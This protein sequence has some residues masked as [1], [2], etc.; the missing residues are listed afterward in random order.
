MTGPVP[1]LTAT[2]PIDRRFVALRRRRN[3]AWGA[4]LAVAALVL[5]TGG[6]ARFGPVPLAVGGLALAAA[7][8][9][10]LV[11]DFR[12]GTN[13][14]RPG[15][16]TPSFVLGT[17]GSAGFAFAQS[18][19][20]DLRWVG[21]LVH[22]E[23][24]TVTGAAADDGF[25]V[26]PPLDGVLGA[27]SGDLGRVPS[28]M[29]A[30]AVDGPALWLCFPDRDWLVC[31]PRAAE[32]AH[33][34]DTLGPVP[35]PSTGSRAPVA[36]ST[37]LRQGRWSAGTS[38]AAPDPAAPSAGAAPVPAGPPVWSGVVVPLPGGSDQLLVGSDGQLALGSP[39]GPSPRWRGLGELE[40]VELGEVSGADPSDGWTGPHGW[41]GVQ[42]GP[43]LWLRLPDEDWLV[44]SER[45][46]EVVALLTTVGPLP[47]PVP[48]ESRPASGPTALRTGRWTPSEVRVE[49]TT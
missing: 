15:L 47:W 48:G 26:R 9:Y 17:D 21:E 43:A 42:D 23:L 24:G 29:W 3:Y 11:T 32:I 18:R 33:L 40:L 20:R 36:A 35:W 31:T 5:V 25:A 6:S 12:L 49:R 16:V 28:W 41:V 45:V 44:C 38:A 13:G 22:A 10:A 19:Q 2:L 30:Q 27:L 14:R 7:F 8:G 1:R 4:V 34:L 37:A 39:A 46:L